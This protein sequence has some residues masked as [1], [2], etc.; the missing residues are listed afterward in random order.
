M[1]TAIT[2][3]VTEGRMK[4]SEYWLKKPGRSI[5]GRAPGCYPRLPSDPEHMTVSR[6]HCLLE[7]DP[8]SVRV[9][10]IGSRNGTFING[11]MIGQRPEEEAEGVGGP[12]FPERELTNGDELRVGD[13]VFRVS[14]NADGGAAEPAGAAMAAA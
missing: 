12:I 10:D 4:G 2:L 14:I 7:I 11:E 9:R 13:T 8:P 5:I 6:R 1:F 3:A